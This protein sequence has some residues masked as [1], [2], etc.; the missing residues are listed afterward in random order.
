VS[1]DLTLVNSSF[2]RV[3]LETTNGDVVFDSD[4]ATDGTFSIKTINGDLDIKFND[5]ISARFDIESFNG[6]IR[7]CFG[8]EPVRTSRYGPGTELKFTEGDGAAR[9]SIDTLNGDLRLCK[10]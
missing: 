10:D 4:L 1:G 6:D 3:R 2:D 5:A 8:P 7:N 9:V